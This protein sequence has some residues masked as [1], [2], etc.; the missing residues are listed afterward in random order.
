MASGGVERL[1]RRA[2]YLR[3]QAAN[4]RVA[5][6]GLLLQAAPAPPDNTTVTATAFRVGFTASRKVGNAVLR[7][8][9]RRRLKALA[10]EMLSSHAARGH[11]YVLVARQATPARPFADLRRDLEAA[12]KKLRLWQAAPTPVAA[13]EAAT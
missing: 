3:V 1:R 12:L 6:P 10:A 4:R 7:N 5:L 13:P 2:D 8:R 11:D 9:A